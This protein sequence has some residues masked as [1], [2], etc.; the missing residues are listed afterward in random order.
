MKKMPEVNLS[1][2]CLWESAGNPG[3]TPARY[4]ARVYLFGS[5][6][7]GNALKY[8]DIDLLVRLPKGKLSPEL[9]RCMRSA[10]EESMLP[11]HVDI[12]DYRSLTPIFQKN[13]DAHRVLLARWP[14]ERVVVSYRLNKNLRLRQNQDTTG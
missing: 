13:V 9:H 11:Y 1:Q 7:K 10:F 5:R 14:R 2:K 6:V 4:G 3:T 8:S 12:L